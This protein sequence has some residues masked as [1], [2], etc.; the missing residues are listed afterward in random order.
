[1]FAKPFRLISQEEE[2]DTSLITVRL[3]P[4]LADSSPQGV[5]PGKEGLYLSALLSFNRAGSSNG[6]STLMGL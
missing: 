2:W 4:T 3:L 6:K 5:N 1:M